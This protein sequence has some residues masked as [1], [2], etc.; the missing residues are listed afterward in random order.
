MDAKIDLDR[1]VTAFSNAANALNHA[2][3]DGCQ[4]EF[5]TW[6]ES[7]EFWLQRIHR[8]MREIAKEETS[9]AG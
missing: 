3:K 9:K 1:Y 8:A 6:L 7:A 4:L 5:N 2:H